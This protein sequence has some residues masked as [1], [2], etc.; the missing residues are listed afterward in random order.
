MLREILQGN[1]QENAPRFLDRVDVLE[2]IRQGFGKERGGKEQ[3]NT[4]F[5]RGAVCSLGGIG[6]NSIAARETKTK[7]EIQGDGN[8]FWIYVE[9]TASFLRSFGDIAVRPKLDGV[10]LNLHDDNLLLV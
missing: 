8:L 10:K 3:P 5:R 4:S 7:L 9:R 6:K 2:K 1:A